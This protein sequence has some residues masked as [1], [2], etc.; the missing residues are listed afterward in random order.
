[1]KTFFY[2]V[3]LLFVI[4]LLSTSGILRMGVCVKGIGCLTSGPNGYSFTGAGSVLQ[5][6]S[7]GNPVPGQ[8]TVT[9]T[10]GGATTFSGGQGTTIIVDPGEVPSR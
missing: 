10:S 1:M 6:G 8:T 3:G 5:S 2:V 4:L 7:I 9:S